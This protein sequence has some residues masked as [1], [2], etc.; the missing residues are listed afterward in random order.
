MAVPLVG[1][2]VRV[3][4]GATTVVGVV[5][6]HTRDSDR[7][8]KEIE[9]V[10]DSEPLLPR[11]LTELAQWL[12]RYYH[13]PIGDV[14]AT[15]LPAKARRG[16]PATLMKEVVWHWTGSEE[17]GKLARA[18]RQHEVFERLRDAWQ[19]LRLRTRC[20]RSRTALP[21]RP[22]GQGPRPQRDVVAK[23]SRSGHVVPPVDRGAG[24]GRGHDHGDA[25]HGDDT[26]PR[27][28]DRQRQDRG[29]PAD[30]RASPV[31][32]GARHWCW[33]PKSP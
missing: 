4:F 7:A 12:A 26:S 30:H 3:P 6:G 22:C 33:F 20:P 24:R 10:L 14:F 13:H 28:R 17:D 32:L 16:A 29:L 1:T 8:A 18:P 19:R 25:R 27:W 5:A 23:L 21:R 11:D 15:L 2:R 31:R 9:E